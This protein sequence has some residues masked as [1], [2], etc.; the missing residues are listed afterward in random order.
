MNEEHSKKKGLKDIFGEE[1]EIKVPIYSKYYRENEPNKLSASKYMNVNDEQQKNVPNHK[2]SVKE[3]EPRIP[4]E[5]YS[6]PD[7]VELSKYLR[8]FA[9]YKENGEFPPKD[10]YES[11]LECNARIDEA[12]E[13][14]DLKKKTELEILSENLKNNA[15]KNGLPPL[16][17]SIEMFTVDDLP[18]IRKMTNEEFQAFLLASLEKKFIDFGEGIVDLYAKSSLNTTMMKYGVTDFSKVKLKHYE[19]VIDGKN[20]YKRNYYSVTKKMF[21]YETAIEDE[22]GKIVRSSASS[23]I[24][25]GSQKGVGILMLVIVGLMGLLTCWV[26]FS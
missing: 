1:G 25:V 3:S 5:M 18:M 8:E 13:E 21:V 26:A 17:G 23:S 7:I 14:E 9:S 20:Y 11:I 24:P 16:V 19:E 2:S 15:S 12:K 4:D 6:N 22:N 10:L